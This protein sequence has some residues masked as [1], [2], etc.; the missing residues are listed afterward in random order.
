[1]TYQSEK[2]VYFP[3]MEVLKG[4]ANDILICRAAVSGWEAYYTLLVIHSHE[5]VRRLLCVMEQSD[6]GKECCEEVFQ[7]GDEYC[8]VFPYVK[9]RQMKNFY[10]PAQIS[11]E[12]Q[13]VICENLILACMLSKL[14]YPLLYLALEQEQLHLRKDYSVEPGCT[15]E[16]DELDEKIGERECARQCAALLR[17]LL[18]PE[19]GEGSMAYRLLQKKWDYETF[20]SLYRDM[21]LVKGTLKRQGRLV[22]LRLLLQSRREGVFW[23]FRLICVGVM[24]LALVC[25]LS[26]AAWGELPFLRLWVNHFKMIGTLSLTE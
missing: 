20:I 1:M 19:S 22:R 15:I 24:F 11:P 9:E 21:R 17:E 2:T 7:Q 10:M 12:E 8:A 4:E 23:L 16:L 25:L 13:G 5:I 14:P 26:R 18:K 6:Y 3:V